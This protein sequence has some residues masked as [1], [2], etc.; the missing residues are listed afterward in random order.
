MSLLVEPDQMQLPARSKYLLLDPKA[1]AGFKQ[2]P[3]V[4]PLARLPYGTL[5]RNL[6]AGCQ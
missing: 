1:L 4:E 2:A 6:D 5:Y 3:R